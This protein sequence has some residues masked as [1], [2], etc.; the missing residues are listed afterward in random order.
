MNFKKSFI[1][2][3]TV[4][5]VLSFAGMVFAANT[6][7]IT[8]TSEPIMKG[9]TCDKAGGF[10]ITFDKNTV[11]TDGDQITFDLDLGAT[12]CRDIDMVIMDDD[13]G[14]DVDLQDPYDGA[15]GYDVGWI[16]AG[17]VPGG[18]VVLTDAGGAV[19]SSTLGGV[20]FH[21]YGNEGSAR[22]TLD[23]IGNLLTSSFTVGAD[24]EDN[25]A[26]SFLVQETNTGYANDGVFIDDNDD[27]DADTSIYDE[28]ATI[29]DNTLCIDVSNPDFTENTVNANYD[30][31]GDKFTF[32]P[33][34]PQIAHVVSATA[35]TLENC[36]GAKTG[37]I[38]VPSEQGECSPV[39]YETGVGYCP[40]SHNGNKL[41][42]VNTGAFS[43][44]TYQIKLE[45]LEP[46]G[47]Y[48]SDG[49]VTVE[50]HETK[51]DACSDDVA[52][53]TFATGSYT[54]Y[55]SSAMELDSAD[56]VA[57]PDACVVETEAQAKTILTGEGSIFTASNQRALW[58]DIP[59]IIYDSSVAA[60]QEINV[61][62]TLI[63]APCGELFSGSFLVGTFGCS[64]SNA[65]TLLYPYF[66][67]MGADSD[68]WWDG[69]VVINTG[70][71]DGEAS[72]TVYEQ[73]GDVATMTIPVSANSMYVNV[74]SSM[75]S[76][77][78]H[79]T[80]GEGT[81]GNSAVY[82][83]VVTD[84]SADGFA[85]IAQ[86]NSGESMGYLPRAN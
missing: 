8:V 28:A 24:D 79:V 47:A 57:Q 60:G 80:S 23:V 66:T 46:A 45:I 75:V 31:L 27:N 72:L 19:S 10:T 78:T 18:P 67:S 61:K 15:V 64:V 81:L 13:G 29:A 39:A 14:G 82:I 73:D 68:A 62:V 35:L 70:S 50:G 42:L 16:P 44:V 22:V 41:L 76:E 55:N 26:I 74:L 11:L 21:I 53:E 6:A 32:I 84:F 86:P 30:S 20:Y 33:S 65:T 36:K 9:A 63:K 2:A 5:A 58:I 77:M 56:I 38:P 17:A 7:T 52:D 12:L 85:M 49:A 69:F 51:T 43:Q 71:S 4:A 34:N 1:F 3:A 25:L 54:Y 48:W 83:K 59:N 37:N 40:L